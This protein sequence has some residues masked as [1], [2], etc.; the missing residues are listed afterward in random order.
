MK[1]QLA[2]FIFVAALVFVTNLFFK[3]SKQ[4]S[5]DI[6][7]A[8][9]TAQLDGTTSIRS[10]QGSEPPDQRAS[11]ARWKIYLSKKF[12]FTISYPPQ[13]ALEIGPAETTA[14]WVS[15]DLLSIYN[16]TDTSTYEFRAIPVNVVISK[17]PLVSARIIYHSVDDYVRGEM[18]NTSSKYEIVPLREV[19]AV[20]ISYDHGDAEDASLEEYVFI[21]N[22]VIY[23]VY[24]KKNDPYRVKIVQSIDL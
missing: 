1:S 7:G 14:D 18:E 10:A 9:T 21:K 12:D 6:Q 8:S 15:A 11:T 3:T 20:H 2:I 19:K 16:P 22:D 23:Q 17:Q 13:Y 24:L 4:Q 5:A